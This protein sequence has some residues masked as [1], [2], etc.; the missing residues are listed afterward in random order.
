M[1]TAH[2]HVNP[3]KST[4][5]Q[6]MGSQSLRPLVLRRPEHLHAQLL[7]GR[8]RPVRIAQELAREDRHIGLP[9]AQDVIGLVGAR[10][11]SRRR[12]S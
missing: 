7:R 4:D 2:R 1:V 9:G 6:R 8:E 10:G 12:L 11:S 3:R 5:M